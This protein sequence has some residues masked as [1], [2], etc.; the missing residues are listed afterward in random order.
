MTSLQIKIMSSYGLSMFALLVFV[1]LVIADLHYQYTHIVEGE[2]VNDF[3]FASQE[4]RHS[5]KNLFLYRNENDLNQLHA[6]LDIVL[7]AF[8][9]G[10]RTFAEIATPQEL[11]QIDQLLKQYQAELRAYAKLS[12]DAKFT[13][14]QQI[15]NTGRNLSELTHDFSQ[16]QRTLLSN[17]TQV[18]VWTLIVASITVIL[19]GIGSAIFVIRQV[20][21]PLNQLEKQLDELA[22]GSEKSLTLV[23]NDKESQS[24]VHHFNSMLDR[25]RA[26][27]NQL[28]HHEKAAALGVLVSGVAHELNNP[29]SNI[30]TSV[31]LLLEDDGST[32]EELRHQWLSHVDSETERARRIVRRLLDTVRQPKLHMKIHTAANLVQT[33]VLLIHRLLPPTVLLHIE[34]IQDSPL[35]VER[36]RIQQVFINLIKNAVDAGATNI[37]VVARETN[38]SESLPAN[39]DYL[40]GEINHISQCARVVLFN[41]DDDGPGIPADHLAQI[42]DPFFTTKSSGEGT[43]LGLYMVEEIISEHDGCMSVENLQTGGTRFSIWLP[44]ATTEHQKQQQEPSEEE[45]L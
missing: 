17:I 35:L 4:L 34:D 26:Q 44:L 1:A 14:Q 27:Q 12:G 8:A 31:Q 16:R 41:I 29:L 37:A 3:Y 19:L 24:F 20:V 9:R 21:R 30:S 39:T 5:E 10:Q 18:V 25:L 15:A 7:K 28:R 43:G 32:R 13:K 40:V 38:W 23:S 45:A 36:E 2:S 33:A 42:F 22:E 6:Q 11:Q